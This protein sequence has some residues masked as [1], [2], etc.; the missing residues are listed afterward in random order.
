[1]SSI[2]LASYICIFVALIATCSAAYQATSFARPGPSSNE[3]EHQHF[4]NGTNRNLKSQRAIRLDAVIA[5]DK[6][7]FMTWLNSNSD[8]KLSIHSMD[9]ADIGT[10][11]YGVHKMTYN[12]NTNKLFMGTATG[13]EFWLADC[14]VNHDYHT[15]MGLQGRPAAHWYTCV[16]PVESQ[17]ILRI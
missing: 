13:A 10:G 6:H 17:F 9:G 7:N 14:H 4:I 1:M 16:F 11:W 8:S 15:I 12:F 3:I 2:K 5:T